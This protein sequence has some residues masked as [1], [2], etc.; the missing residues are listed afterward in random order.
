MKVKPV[1]IPID[2]S[3][4]PIELMG[5]LELEPG[6]VFLDSSEASTGSANK[7][8]IAF[9]PLKLLYFENDLLY[10]MESGKKIPIYK[11]PFEYIRE[12]LAQ[13]EIENCNF[14]PGGIIGYIS[15]DYGLRFENLSSKNNSLINMPDLFFG[16]YENALL[17][18]KEKLKWYAVGV[19]NVETLSKYIE[20]ITKLKQSLGKISTT[21]K[22][23]SNFTYDDYIT[24]VL[25][26]KDYI[27]NGDIYQVNLAQQFY[28]YTNEKALDLYANLREKN[29][30][31]YSAFLCLDDMRFV[32]S[33][34]PELFLEVNDR[35]V[36][37]RPI[38]GTIRR[39]V[40]STEDEQLKQQLL[41]SQKDNA[42]LTMII[43][44]ERNDLNRVCKTGSVEVKQLKQ[45]ETYASVHHLVS[46]ICGEL[47]DEKD[48]FDLLKS[49]FPG[50][51]ITGAPKVRAMQII[52][53]LEPHKR[54][55][56][57]GSIG[58]IAFNKCAKFNIA[59]RT[60][61]YNK[62]NLS[63]GLGGGIVIDS[64]PELEY[65]ETLHKG[66][67]ILDAINGEIV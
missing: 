50:G 26:A 3:L 51:S 33:S 15:Y 9:N 31:P 21:T 60:I 46:I 28:G 39:G 34:S 17:F 12:L 43:D 61:A 16:F 8:I 32:M 38:K 44:L 24:A 20:S 23:S 59:I 27:E 55:I 2:I 37:T 13:Y 10:E 64:V 65:Q 66:K 67:A 19:E 53:E 5:C 30:A 14:F 7:S 54:G 58:Y 22:L 29:P 47:S 40:S 52:D 6:T 42:E 49:A 63:I 36:E 11:N 48:I 41:K 45:L 18:D 25:K 62:G 57:T 35:F 4:S 1:A 56:Y